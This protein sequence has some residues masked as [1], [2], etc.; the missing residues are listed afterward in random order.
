MGVQVTL[1]AQVATCIQLRW[2][3]EKGALINRTERVHYI[4]NF[5]ITNAGFVLCS[6]RVFI[7]MFLTTIALTEKKTRLCG[8]MRV[9]KDGEGSCLLARLL[10]SFP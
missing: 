3:N 1:W 4:S 5:T 7:E 9:M 10:A 2:K 8:M 6:Y